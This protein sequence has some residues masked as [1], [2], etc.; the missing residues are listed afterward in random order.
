[1]PRK[2]TIENTSNISVRSRHVC[3]VQM[4]QQIF[5]FQWQLCPLAVSQDILSSI[6]FAGLRATARHIS[7]IF[8]CTFSMLHKKIIIYICSKL[9]HFFWNSP[10]ASLL[11]NYPVGNIG[12]TSVLWHQS[13]GICP[14]ASFPWHQSPGISPLASVLLHRSYTIHHLASILWHKHSGICPVA[15]IL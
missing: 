13:S 5:V 12:L 2:I 15:S 6:W 11:A 14:L 1:M 4:I 3:E 7:C 8:L 10:S 9:Q